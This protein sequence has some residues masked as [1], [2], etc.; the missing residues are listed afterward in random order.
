M[1]F[2][3]KVTQDHINK[4]ERENGYE[5][6]ISLAFIDMPNVVH[7]PYSTPVV[8]EEEGI[9][10]FE[11]TDGT[12]YKAILPKNVVEFIQAFDKNKEVEPIEFEID[13]DVIGPQ[14]WDQEEYLG[15]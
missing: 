5:C 9:A 14:P 10:K 13:A 8:G 11:T 6:A 1:K 15:D 12:E 7:V 4:G 2:N 3:I